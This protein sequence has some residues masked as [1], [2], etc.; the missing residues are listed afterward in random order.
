MINGKT[1]L[2]AVGPKAL[3]TRKIKEMLQQ[4][5]TLF[6]IT[7]IATLILLLC[8]HS[9][10][11]WV[12]RMIISAS[13]SSVSTHQERGNKILFGRATKGMWGQRPQWSPGVKPW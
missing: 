9:A 11:K 13:L 5:S 3:C 2:G 8:K 4:T 7:D 6:Y 10:R 12:R 1:E